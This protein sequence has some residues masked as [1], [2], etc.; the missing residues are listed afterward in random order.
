[1]GG[2]DGYTFQFFKRDPARNPADSQNWLEET[3]KSWNDGRIR[4]EIEARSRLCGMPAVRVSRRFSGGG[5]RLYLVAKPD[6]LFIVQS[7][8]KWEPELQE[9]ERRY[10]GSFELL[11]CRR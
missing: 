3:L 4:V 5:T 8:E 10:F 1:M 2:S 6:V 7:G 11:D 9:A